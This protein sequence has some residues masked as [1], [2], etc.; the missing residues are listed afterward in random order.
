MTSVDCPK[1]RT[2]MELCD[3]DCYKCPKCGKV[4]DMFEEESL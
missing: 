2:P 1:C 3:V 4:V